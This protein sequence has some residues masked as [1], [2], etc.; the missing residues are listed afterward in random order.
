MNVFIEPQF[1][2]LYKKFPLTLIDIGASGGIQTNWKPAQ[3]YLRIIGFE[4]DQR[5]FINLSK[6]NND[7]IRYINS[8]LYKEKTSVQLH[9]A[10]KQQ[11]SSILEPNRSFIE[12]F[13]GAERFDVVEKVTIEAD[14]LDRQF[15]QNQVGDVDFLKVDAEGAELYILQGAVQTI[16]DKLTG[17]EIEVGFNELRK[18]QPLFSEVDSF[19]RIHFSIVPNSFFSNKSA[20]ACRISNE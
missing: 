1:T 6:R 4:P 7:K 20:I 14:T 11:C 12:K 15:E 10:S 13:S 5:E 17:L 3:K 9:M 16:R 19:L 8:A 18:N 2:H